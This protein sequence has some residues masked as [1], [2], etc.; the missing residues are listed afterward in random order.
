M[1][2]ITKNGIEINTEDIELSEAIIKQI[3]SA[4]DK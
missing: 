3:I 4:I 1:V 2:K